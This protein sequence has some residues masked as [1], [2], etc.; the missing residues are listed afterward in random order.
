M[1]DLSPN[2]LQPHPQRRAILDL[3][4]RPIG[5]EKVLPH[6]SL[7]LIRIAVP[8]GH[9]QSPVPILGELRVIQNESIAGLLQ[10]SEEVYVLQHPVQ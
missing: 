3:E 10:Q 5:F 9:D 6:G 1:A 2:L 7:R 4:P 8:D